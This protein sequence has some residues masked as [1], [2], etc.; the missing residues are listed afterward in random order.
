VNHRVF[1]LLATYDLVPDSGLEEDLI[2]IEVLVDNTEHAVYRCRVWGFRCYVA[3]LLP[4]APHIAPPVSHDRLAHELTWLLD[5]PA[6]IAGRR[7]TTES[8]FLDTVKLAV[9]RLIEVMRLPDMR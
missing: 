2:R 4:Q 5:D 1:R 7:A 3:Q 8:E 6:L 9:S